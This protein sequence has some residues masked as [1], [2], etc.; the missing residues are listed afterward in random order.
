VQHLLCLIV[1]PEADHGRARRL[2]PE[3]TAALTEAGAPHRVVESASLDHARELAAEAASRGEV[4]VAFG[5]DG[6]AGALA[7]AAASA[8]A[9]YGLIPAGRGNDFASA[10]GIPADVAGA[11][12]ILATGECR[13]IDLIGV[14]VPGHPELLVAGSVYTGL[15]A[16]AGQ[17]A[18]ATRLLGGS[19]VYP[20]AALRALARWSPVAF[21]VQV[22]G[23]PGPYE[24]DGYAVVVANSGYFGAGMRVA[25]PAVIDDGVLDIVLMRHASK[26]TFIQVLLK[27]KDGSHVTLPQI[28]LHR[29]TD[30]TITMSRDLPAAADGEP[31]ACASPLGA[32]IP[33][34]C[35]A[36]PAALEV[37]GPA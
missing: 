23:Q 9:R 3:C 28:S 21:T 20:V 24:F 10:L 25:P 18:N 19:L 37:I 26:L 1:N 2:L 34:R 8:G 6:M 35:R 5:G 32:G 14:S 33:L 27:I 7:G 16:L 17:L 15:P 12:R 13:P 31:L 22:D 30:V 36:L 4:V 29:G 11:A